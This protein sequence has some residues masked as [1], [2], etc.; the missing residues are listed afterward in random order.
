M[1]EVRKY[2]LV[3]LPAWTIASLAMPT[4][5]STWS[6]GGRLSGRDAQPNA[7]VRHH[8]SAMALVVPG[9]VKGICCTCHRGPVL[10]PH[11][12]WIGRIHPKGI[13]PSSFH[14]S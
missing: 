2:V 5:L 6:G 12:E 4:S 1:Q 14:S 13:L 9:R 8:T 7:I 10:H 3:A 11:L